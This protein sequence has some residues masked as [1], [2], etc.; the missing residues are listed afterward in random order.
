MN[1]K[2]GDTHTHTN[3]YTHTHIHTHTHMF[4]SGIHQEQNTNYT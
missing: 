4:V 1:A 2:H 3:T